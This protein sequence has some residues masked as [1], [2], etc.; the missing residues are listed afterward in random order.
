VEKYRWALGLTKHS[1]KE[2][3]KLVFS[4]TQKKCTRMTPCAKIQGLN[5]VTALDFLHPDTSATEQTNYYYLS[6]Q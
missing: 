5:S 6:Y 1:T 2:F 3:Q 4:D